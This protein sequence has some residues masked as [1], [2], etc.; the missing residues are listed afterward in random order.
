MHDVFGVLEGHWPTRFVYVTYSSYHVQ[1]SFVPTTWHHT[2][3]SHAVRGEDRVC[4]G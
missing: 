3:F 2:L 4:R 1:R